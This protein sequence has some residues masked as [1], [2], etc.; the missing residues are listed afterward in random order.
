MLRSSLALA[1]LSAKP[2]RRTCLLRLQALIESFI[3]ANEE[4]S[5]KELLGWCIGQDSL[6]FAEPQ[7]V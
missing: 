2:K 4:R 5:T 1:F 7:S 6:V 3:R